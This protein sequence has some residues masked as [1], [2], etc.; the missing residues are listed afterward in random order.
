MNRRVRAC[1]NAQTQTDTLSHTQN[2]Y[3]H[4]TACISQFVS[5][6]LCMRSRGQ[7][8]RDAMR[9][10]GSELVVMQTQKVWH[11]E[12]VS[13]IFFPV[14]LRKNNNTSLL[15]PSKEDVIVISMVAFILQ[16]HNN[17]HVHTLPWGS[18][19]S[20]ILKT[21]SFCREK[22]SPKRTTK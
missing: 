21:L 13:T 10:P 12:E 8:R 20:N 11:L 17:I 1:A 15:S 19:F 3:F 22:K 5:L 16:S 14:I 2:T 18:Q 4:M 7:T 9:L 6:S